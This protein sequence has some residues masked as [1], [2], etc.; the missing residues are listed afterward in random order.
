MQSDHFHLA[1]YIPPKVMSKDDN[2][3]YTAAINYMIEI[4]L[5]ICINFI[6]DDNVRDDS[7]LNEG[8]YS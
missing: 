1:K 2:S 3:L 8:K 4:T 5:E 6:L 7:I